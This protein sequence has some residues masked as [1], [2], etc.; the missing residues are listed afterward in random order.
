MI[1]VYELLKGPDGVNQVKVDKLPFSKQ[2][3]VSSS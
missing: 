2:K 1:Y 3:S